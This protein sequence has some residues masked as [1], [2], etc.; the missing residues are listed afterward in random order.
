MDAD[1][2]E[3]AEDLKKRDDGQIPVLYRCEGLFPSLLRRICGS[4]GDRTTSHAIPE[5]SWWN[6]PAD[7][8]AFSDSCHVGAVFIISA[9]ILRSD[10]LHPNGLGKTL[11]CVPYQNTIRPPTVLFVPHEAK[12]LSRG[13][14]T[15]QRQ[16]FS[17]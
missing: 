7:C 17:L 6:E 4:P 10:A 9:G 5:Q 12:N 11:N 2:A 3:I 15:R 13:P 1:D 8:R 14:Q 16:R